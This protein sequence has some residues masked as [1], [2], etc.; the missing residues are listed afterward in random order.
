MTLRIA[1][2]ILASVLLLTGITAAQYLTIT[3]PGGS[4]IREN[5]FVTTI[6]GIPVTDYYLWVTGSSSMSGAP[7]DQPPVL[8]AGQEGIAR[9]PAGGP[10]AIGSHVV[11]GGGTIRGDVPKSPSGGTGY[12]A[13]VT[14]DVGG[15]R[16]VIW[17]T[18]QDTAT[19]QYD[20]R[21]EGGP[22]GNPEYDETSV[23]VTRGTLTVKVETVTS[24]PAGQPVQVTTAVTTPQVMVTSIPTTAAPSPTLTPIPVSTP[25]PTPAAGFEAC[26]TFAGIAGAGLVLAGSKRT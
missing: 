21:V 8:L 25:P 3:G 26:M 6:A 2:L 23:T 1:A 12:Y 9:D 10:Y 7:G 15:L 5:T 24:T 14:T 4:V 11:A 22:A 18:S 13:L 16:T 17:A 20:I 19:G